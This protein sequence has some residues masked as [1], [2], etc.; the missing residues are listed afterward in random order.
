MKYIIYLAVGVLAV[1]AVWYVIR[2]VRRQLR[3]ECGCGEAARGTAVPAKKVAQKESEIP[4]QNN[5]CYRLTPRHIC[6]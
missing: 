1:W 6:L 5:W 2:H 3:G 4:P